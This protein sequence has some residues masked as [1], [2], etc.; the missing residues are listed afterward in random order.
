[1]RAHSFCQHP[2]GCHWCWLWNGLWLL[3]FQLNQL[4]W[5][6]V[7]CLSLVR[8]R[9][10]LIFK[11]SER[12]CLWRRPI[13][14]RGKIRFFRWFVGEKTS[15]PIL[16]FRVDRGFHK[17]SRSRHSANYILLLEGRHNTRLEFCQQ[18]SPNIY[19]IY[20]DTLFFEF[21]LKVLRDWTIFFYSRFI[22]DKIIWVLFQLF[23]WPIFVGF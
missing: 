15:F 11:L 2:K 19:A 7:A 5:V 20:L 14:F 18:W 17:A 4:V 6:G 1:M 23:Q 8:C 12:V 13:R 22:I 9:R 10:R 3:R 21:V 16:L